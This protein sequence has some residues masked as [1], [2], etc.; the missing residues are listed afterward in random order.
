MSVSEDRSIVES[1][2]SNP[3]WVPDARASTGP[4]DAAAD[5]IELPD[6][7]VD[8][9]P[10]A[11]LETIPLGNVFGVVRT[12]FTIPPNALGFAIT[13]KAG[14]PFPRFGIASIFAPSGEP[15]HAMGIPWNGTGE[16]SFTT[17]GDYAV[18]GVPQSAH[19]DALAVTPGEWQVTLG[20]A[21]N[22]TVSFQ[23]TP[24]GKFHG[25]LLDVNFYVP[26]GVHLGG[27]SVPTTAALAPLDRVVTDRVDAFFKVIK[28]L[29]GL[30]RGR[31]KYVAIASKYREIAESDLE[32][33]WK[34]TVP[35]DTGR[36][37]HIILSEFSP[38]WWGVAP[39]IPGV[40]NETGNDQSGMVLSSIEGTTADEEGFVL[41]HELGHFLGLNH[42][43]EFNDLGFDPLDDTPQCPGL[44]PQ[45]V[46][47]CPDAK[48]IMAPTGI[49]ESPIT[50]SPLQQRV[51]QGSPAY[52]AF[53]T[54]DPPTLGTAFVPPIGWKRMFGHPGTPL[55]RGERIVAAH[56]CGKTKHAPIRDAR[57]RADLT[58]V[59]QNPA[60]PKFARAVANKLLS[61]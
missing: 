58:Q 13:A 4:I 38:D 23:R 56:L 14:S 41:A 5:S 51:V 30:S 39:S 24:D 1:D 6:V 18:A 50:T 17:F 19:V 28:S 36:G 37:V 61:R 55:D 3:A 45:T 59:A 20:G 57:T 25:G 2:A 26:D 46:L 48:N 47:D 22:V 8:P 60:A 10:T 21:G 35:T 53:L 7:F 34:L 32:D 40:P 49:M 33:A 29:Y 15:V 44:T 16:T 9:T 12:P 42:T 54:G 27:S 11:Q 31:V 52:R 43:S